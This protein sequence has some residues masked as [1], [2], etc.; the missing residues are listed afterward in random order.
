MQ[1]EEIIT[2][3]EQRKEG[4]LIETQK[5][6]GKY[7]LS[8][9]FH[10][11]GNWEDAEEC[12]NDGYMR[13]WNSIPPQRPAVLS[14]F[15][16][17]IV[18]NLALNRYKYAQAKKR[19]LG[20]VPLVLSELEECIGTE[21]MKEEESTE[22]EITKCIEEFLNIQTQDNRIIFVKRYWYLSSIEEISSSLKIS[23]SKVKSSLFRT[24][25]KLKKHL[26]KEG[27]QI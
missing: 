8:I 16:G 26:K 14:A 6:Y 15:W 1:D 25:N 2:L 22:Q 17:R 27:I 13:L 18:R 24:R 4:A 20:Q 12:V 21:F 19:N 5:K 10:I 23:E 11:L 3:Y 9:A 7:G